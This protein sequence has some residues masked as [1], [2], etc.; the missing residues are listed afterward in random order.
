M[1]LTDIVKVGTEHYC[2][3]SCWTSDLGY[4][5]MVFTCDTKGSITNQHDLYA[6]HYSNEVEMSI[7][8]IEV[9]NALKQINELMNYINLIEYEN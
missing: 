6:K 9:V 5:T 7:G 1:K 4:E 3:D 2:V 8:H